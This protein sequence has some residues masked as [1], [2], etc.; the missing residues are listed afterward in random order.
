[1]PHA[2]RPEEQAA[3][4]LVERVWHAL[5]TEAAHG[6]IAPDCPGLD[7]SGPEAVLAWH[8]DRRA[9][10]PDLTYVVD[11]V[12]AASGHAAIR[13]TAT[14]HQEGAFGPV[15]PT[16]REATYSGAT[17]LTFDAQGRIADVWSVNDLFGL[18]QQLGA[19]V[20]PP[21]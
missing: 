11:D 20:L 3:R 6:L 15:P 1:M 7:G 10:F 8:H 12:V 18:V 4:R 2:T 16:G 5:D 13:W 17:F 14:G 9:A 19:R 21:E